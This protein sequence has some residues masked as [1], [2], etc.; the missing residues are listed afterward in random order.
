M[1]TAQS[2]RPLTTIALLVGALAI[3]AA[4]ASAQMVTGRRIPGYAETFGVVLDQKSYA[5]QAHLIESSAPGNI[6]W[7]GEQPAFTI[8]LVNN[9]DQPIQ[10]A[11]KVDLIA[12]GTRGRPGDIW[13]PQMFRIADAGSVKIDVNLPAKGFTNATVRPKVPEQF[14]AYALVADLGP[15][16]RQFVTSFV[17]TFP[18]ANQRIQYPKF[19]LDV[20]P[21]D[22]LKRLGVQAVRHGVGYKAT[23]DKDFDE[24]FEREGATL[25]EFQDA[26]IAVL[27]MI[28]AGDWF[29]ACQPLGRP[30]PWLNDKDEMLDTKTDIAWMP[31]WDADF[32]KFVRLFARAC[33]WPRGPINAFS[34]WNEPWEGLSISGWGADMPRYR[35]IYTRMAQAI[36]A[37]RREDGADVLVGGCDS[38]SNALDKLFGDGSDA[39]LQRFDFVSIHYQGMDPGSTIKAWVDRKSP[40]GRVKIWDTESWVA[41]TD[42][43]VAAVVAVNRSAG[44]DRAM[45]I[46]HGN[47]A[48][49]REYER[50]I[51]GGKK[52]R[53]RTADAWSVAAAIGAATHF[54]G[55]RDFR[56]VLFTSGLPWVLV[57]DGLAGQGGKPDPEDGTIVVVGDIGEEFGHD[58]LLFRTARGLK[59]VAHKE[60]LKKKLAAL[61][62]DAPAK[63]RDA[64]EA[65]IAKDEVLSGATMTLADGSAFLRPARFSL[66]DFYGNPVPSKGGRIAVPLDGRGFFLRG[67]GKRGTF[68]DLLKAVRQSRVEGIEPLAT[69]C[70]DMTAPIASRPA[71]RLALTNV[72]NRPVAGTLTVR[73]GDLKVEPASQP[74]AFAA[75]ETKEVAIKV[76]GGSPAPNNTYALALAFDAGKDGRAVHEEDMHVNLIARRTITVDGKLDDWRDVLPQILSTKEKAGPTLTEFAWQPF[77]KFDESVKKG[78]A[79]GYAAYD[80]A[81]FYFAAKIADSTPDEGTCRFETRNDDEYY[82][83]EVSYRI[84]PDKTLKK[85]DAVWEASTD[86]PWALQKPGDAKDRIAAVWETTARALAMDVELPKDRLHQAAFYFI[87]NDPDGRRNQQIEIT[88]LDSKKVLDQRDINN[89]ARGRYAVYHLAGNLRIKLSTRNWLGTS[90]A[91]LFFDPAAGD[92]KTDGA[93]ARFLKFDDDARG[94][95]KGV[96]GADGYHVIG[97]A[98]KYPVYAKVVLLETEDRIAMTWPPG[99]R[100]YSYRKDPDLPSGNFPNHDNVQ[101]GFNVLPAAEKPLYPCPPGTM[102]GYISTRDTDY[103]YA[104]NAVAP[105]YGGGTEIWRLAVPGM[106]RKHFYPRQGKSPK[107]GPV[108]D[109][110][111]VMARDGTTRFVECAIPWT[112]LPD[113]KKRLDAGQTVK[114]S[115]RVNDNAG[116]GCMELSR[117]RSV[118]KRSGSFHVDWGEHWANELEFAFEK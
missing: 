75:H 111:L 86:K 99:V 90:L 48:E 94:N 17:R 89:C 58:A 31:A 43:R 50:R 91:G 40:R 70:R 79:A 68:A 25:K 23:T 74:L 5:Y 20:L 12:Y 115:F 85:R 101:I 45:G 60:E 97:A 61:P 113:V 41:N 112:E 9:T 69:V 16:G 71:L 107:D 53:I 24:W 116:V 104:L 3:L 62:A 28:G 98:E 117:R 6:L 76:T 44:Y 109:G 83:P 78:F 10:A 65:A 38:T 64:L 92:A 51:K 1:S 49:G 84:D 105:K 30:R 15:A 8:Q 46:F 52:Q 54:I 19:C 57:F 33:G 72:L 59:E 26:N 108:K 35:D 103:E 77:K 22:V 102:P 34:L 21:L 29:H 4:P 14:G 66:Y 42:D 37:A 27:F 110:N 106:P 39:F 118:A 82:Y 55:E 87:D 11:G 32:E 95:W 73:L 18:A 67:D 100:R 96:Y 81:C 93:A 2:V 88:D 56:E 13:V 63:E 36:E 47:I 7:P 114:F 80:D